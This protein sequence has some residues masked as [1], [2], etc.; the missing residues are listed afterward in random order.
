MGNYLVKN[1]RKG[2]KCKTKEMENLTKWKHIEYSILVKTVSEQIRS[3]P[4]KSKY[5][6]ADEHLLDFEQNFILKKITKLQHR[7]KSCEEYNL[8]LSKISKA[9][10]GQEALLSL[11]CKIR[12]LYINSGSTNLITRL[13]NHL[14]LINCAL[15]RTTDR[16]C[17]N[18]LSLSKGHLQRIFLAASSCNKLIFSQC[19]LNSQD[20]RL[21]EHGY[22]ITTLTFLSCGLPNLSNWRDFPERL[23]SLLTAC[24]SCPLSRSL[25]KL[26]I[27]DTHLCP[28]QKEVLI[29][30]CRFPNTKTIMF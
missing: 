13:R 15:V 8:F 14:G 19:K 11:P 22:Q 21:R 16:I 6:K 10:L 30:T 20:L 28:I 1:N 18:S 17:L 12:N 5:Q 25:V 2:Y 9:R 23:R 24:S 27:D 4:I 26:T 3:S 7:L 29:R